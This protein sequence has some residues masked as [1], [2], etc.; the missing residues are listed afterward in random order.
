MLSEPREAS[1]LTTRLVLTFVEREGGRAA[2]EEVLSRCGLSDREDELR[3]EN[4]WFPITPAPTS[5]RRPPP[6]SGPDVARR[7]GSAAIGLNVG[8]A[9]KL[10]LRAL[11][12][13]KL[14]YSNI[15]R[16]SGSS[17]GFT[18]WTSSIAGST[19]ARIRNVP[20]GDAA[21]HRLR[22]QHGPALLRAAG[23]R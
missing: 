22:L 13:P 1:G 15:G 23:L 3:D 12:S 6:R 5:S 20:I 18:A 17:T 14:I 19:S 10:S 11:G 7:I 4:A 9:P 2:V 16:A 8:Q 21:H